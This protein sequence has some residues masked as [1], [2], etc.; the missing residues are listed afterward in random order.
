MLFLFYVALAVLKLSP[1]LMTDDV[2]LCVAAGIFCQFVYLSAMFWLNSI[3]YSMKLLI[4]ILLVWAEWH[5]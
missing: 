1:Q 3:R 5:P 4:R 2:A